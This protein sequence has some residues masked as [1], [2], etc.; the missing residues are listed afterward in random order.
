MERFGN[1][2]NWNICTI[3]KWFEMI[4]GY[5]AIVWDVAWK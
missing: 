3:S 2:D 5:L 1:C 4:F